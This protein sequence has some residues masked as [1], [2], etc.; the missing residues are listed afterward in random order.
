MVVQRRRGARG[1]LPIPSPPLESRAD[2]RVAVDGSLHK[3][4]VKV[5]CFLIYL[6]HPGG[7]RFVHFVSAVFP[8]LTPGVVG[9]SD[10]KGRSGEPSRI[11]VPERYIVSA[12]QRGRYILPHSC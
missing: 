12:E 6:N 9:W 1:F 10:K 11:D 8:P 3:V 7:F 2:S 5:T 4:L